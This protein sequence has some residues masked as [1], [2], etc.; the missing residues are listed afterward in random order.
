VIKSRSDYSSDKISIA[1]LMACHNRAQITK[2]FF[3]SLKMSATDK[4]NLQFYVTDDGST[5]ETY[6][7]LESQ[8]FSIKIIKGDGNLFWAKSMAKAEESIDYQP[9]GLLWVNDDL[10]LFPNAFENLF[11][12]IQSHPR[13]VLVGQVVRKNTNEVI[14][15]GFKS[16][17][18][19]PLKLSL[20]N[21]TQLDDPDTF[22]GNF[23]YI[24]AEIRLAVGPIN[25]FYGHAYADCDYGYRVRELRYEIK[26]I[27]DFIG[28]SETNTVPKFENKWEHIKFFYN[29]KYRLLDQIY[30][31]SKF[32]KLKFKILIP[33]FLVIPLIKIIVTKK[34]S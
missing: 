6:S 31:L 27:P 24:P 19:H 3:E 32:T 12:S 30:F 13:A 29:K 28:E 11:K 7:V 25:S 16:Q 5:D 17:S 15:G 2:S 34:N 33:I 8:P 9:D 22:N 14:Y 1:V 20:L 21:E 23:V 4:F 18:I 26:L 10:K